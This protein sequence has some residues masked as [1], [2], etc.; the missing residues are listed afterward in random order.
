MATPENPLIP[1]GAITGKPKR[2]AIAENLRAYREKGITQFMIYPRSGC[3][4]EYLSEEWFLACRNIIEEAQQAGFTSIWIYDEF[5]WP[6]GTCNKAIPQKHPE[7]AMNQLC[8]YKE[9]DKYN[10]IVRKNKNM[11]DLMNPEAVDCFIEMTHELYARHFGEYMGSLIKGFFTDEPDIAF[12]SYENKE[13][14]LRLPY[15]NGLENDYFNETGNELHEDIIS[16]L[17]NNSDFYQHTTNRLCAEKFRLNFAKKISAWCAKYNMVL[18]GHLMNE[19]SS[20]KALKCNGH[21]LVVLREFSLPGIDEIFTHQKIESIE[22]LTFGTAMNAIENNGNKGGLAELF[23]LGPCDLTPSQIRRQIW[24]AAMFGINKYAMAVAALDH[25]GNAEKSIYFNPFSRTQ[26]WFSL[27]DKLGEDAAK[28]ASFATKTREKKIAVRYPYTPAPL[29][30]LLKHLTQE[31]YAWSL[32]APDE[33]TECEIVLVAENGGI[34]EEKTNKTFFDFQRLEHDLLSKKNLRSA[35]ISAENTAPVR[36]IFLRTFTD[37]TCIVIDFSENSREL[38]LKRKGVSSKF[39]LTAG[40]VMVF[41]GWEVKLDRPNTLRPHFTDNRFTFTVTGQTINVRLA[42]RNYAGKPEIILDGKKVSAEDQCTEF[43]QGF[44]EIYLTSN[45]IS[46]A[47]GTH[48]IELENDV[49]DLPYLPLLWLTGEFSCH[50]H[51]TISP[52]NNDGLGLDSYAGSVSQHATLTIPRETSMVSFETQQLPAELLI[53]G[54]LLGKC[55]WGP[56]FWKIPQEYCGKEVELKLIRYTTCGRIFGKTI[57]TENSSAPWLTE[58]KPSNS[59]KL[60]PFCEA[61]WR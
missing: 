8:I 44:N 1:M 6:S 53:N 32:I 12:F 29:T 31:Q 15:Y 43:P 25:R 50:N 22:W 56:F 13:D 24:L 33:E 14:V 2:D 46:L 3:E 52:Y 20:E 57:F 30:D 48:A 19:F 45:M 16:G 28:A 35:W 51:Q 55:L 23:A 26:P 7:Y 37:G 47:P 58:F 27:Y 34:R 39:T 10:F 4:L 5:N 40:G 11:T 41:P 54:V 60:V 9:D 18:T 61:I 38:I 17:K 42:L 59:E 21:P 36:D 49:E